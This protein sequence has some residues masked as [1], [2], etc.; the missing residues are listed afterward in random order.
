[1]EKLRT[2]EEFI[3]FIRQAVN[4]KKSLAYH[5]LY[6]FLVSCFVRA[7][8]DFNGSVDI[9]EFDSLIEEAAEMPR[10]YGFAPASEV[11]IQDQ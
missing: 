11:C 7:D 6:N 9:S 10:I 5:E 8:K 2:R 4:D 3:V 1:M